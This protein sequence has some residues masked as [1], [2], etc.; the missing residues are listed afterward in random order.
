[1]L[2]EG[3]TGVRAGVVIVCTLDGELLLDLYVVL[4]ALSVVVG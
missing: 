3:D 4:L 2:A 1:M